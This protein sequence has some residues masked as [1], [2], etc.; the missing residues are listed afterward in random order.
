MLAVLNT[1]QT[2]ARQ[3]YYWVQVLPLARLELPHPPD[4]Q[5]RNRHHHGISLA[6]R[7]LPNPQPPLPRFQ[8]LCG[9]FFCCCTAAVSGLCFAAFVL[10]TCAAYS[11][12][13]G[14]LISLSDSSSWTSSSSAASS[15]Q[16]VLT[17]STLSLPSHPVFVTLRVYRSTLRHL[18]SRFCYVCLS[19]ASSRII[20]HTVHHQL[21]QR[22]T[23]HATPQY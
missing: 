16:L 14:V 22:T 4:A 11:Y 23:V 1:G 20:P 12:S 13:S 6:S 10:T 5:R 7:L 15:L 21:P 19:I 3:T 17:L 18:S 2:G 9:F 8:S